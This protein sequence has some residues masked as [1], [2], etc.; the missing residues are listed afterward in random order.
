ME[1]AKLLMQMEVSIK[2]NSLMELKKAMGNA[3]IPQG[4]GTKGCG[5]GESSM[6]GPGFL[7][8]VRV[9]WRLGNLDNGW[10]EDDI[11]S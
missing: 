7:L 8:G 11:C 5:K 6:E 10:K 2:A 9:K 4:K 1:T 3:A